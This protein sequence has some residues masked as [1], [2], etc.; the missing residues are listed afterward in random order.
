MMFQQPKLQISS[1]RKTIHILHNQHPHCKFIFK[2]IFTETPT[3]YWEGHTWR[4][5][6]SFGVPSV[7]RMKRNETAPGEGW[8]L[9]QGPRAF[10]S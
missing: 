4:T 8:W 3:G 9:S 6:P 7:R 10:A 5:V 2:L 1:G